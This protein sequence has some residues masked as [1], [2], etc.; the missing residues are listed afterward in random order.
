[1]V[2]I[3]KLP[4]HLVNKIAA[5]E[6][7]ERPASVLKEL[8]ENSIDAGATRIDV[9][10]EDGG[11]RLIQVTDNGSGM[12]ADDIKLAFAPHATSKISTDDDLFD[13]HTMGFRGEALASVASIS[14]ANI[15]TRTADED[16]GWEVSASGAIL[17]QP[18][19]CPAPVG[20]TVTIRDLFFNTPGRRKFMRTTNTEFGH[21]T[22][23]L[24]RLALP[25][26]QVGFT[27]R[28]NAR[29]VV[30]L[31]AAQSTRQR[32]AD[33]FTKDL[34]GAL[35]TVVDRNSP[36][37]I[38]GFI[39]PPDAARSSA[40]W[41]YVFLNG[42]YIRDRML[43]HATREAYR[44][45]LAP[46]RSPVVFLFVEIDPAEVDVNVH[47]TKIEVRFS[48]SN[49]VYGE[50]LATL[51]E[52]LNR[53]NLT[54]GAV[55]SPDDTKSET[56]KQND[57]Q[58]ETS[59]RAALAD[60]F[61]SAPPQP[62]PE[63]G[64][65]P[66]GGSHRPPQQNRSGQTFTP[67]ER[68]FSG[69]DGWVRPQ[70]LPPQTQPAAPG[71]T[72]PETTTAETQNPAPEAFEL[73]EQTATATP[74]VFQ[75]HNTYIVTETSDGLMIVD[76]H[77]LHERILYNG[78]KRR[79]IDGDEKLHAQ[80]ML[81]PE[82]IEVTPAEAAILENSTKL[83]ARMGIEVSQFAP[84]TYAIQQYPTVLGQRGVKMNAF[85]REL[86]D[87]ISEDETT[88]SERMFEAVLAM[89]ACKA[90]VKSGDPLS[91]DEMLD[92]LAASD[93]QDKASACPHGRPTTLKLTVKDL[94]KQFKRV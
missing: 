3:N 88:D 56:A 94:E 52:T 70:H 21:I 33:L 26:P 42:R 65:S 7:V 12:G 5:G 37:N 23:Q 60:F 57:T 69:T 40:K 45:L 48:N 11:K 32:I 35:L 73:T 43:T 47:P 87:S 90:A 6:V 80:K 55:A 41:S 8:V 59:V 89:M 36:V 84:G 4:I 76:Q 15:R 38:S 1:M 54:P 18:T 10:V 81:I 61:Q 71:S 31:P 30:N 44:G 17:E 75:V 27:L 66:G 25:H 29:E 20:T 72:E 82:T 19:P 51:R 49:A 14:H 16:G 2:H 78:F 92:L 50:M 13:I 53:S 79:L 85:I 62:R 64:G 86:L 74:N 68:Q 24:T 91:V 46:T 77:A 28:H 9:V 83:L 93:G 34:S 39:A 63:A 22:E 58:R 67:P